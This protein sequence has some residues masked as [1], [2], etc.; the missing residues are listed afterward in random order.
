MADAPVESFDDILARRGTDPVAADV[1]RSIY[2]QESGG[3]RANTSEVNSSGARGPMQVI[4]PTFDGLKAKGLIPNEYDWS[5][6]IHNTEAGI[7]LIEDNYDRY[8]DPAATAA[9]YFS[10]PHAVNPDGSINS[11]RRDPSG[12]TV[13]QY[14]SDVLGRIGNTIV[15]SAKAGQ[16]GQPEQPNQVPV[17]TQLAQWILANKNQQGTEQ[18]EQVKNQYYGALKNEGLT[19][20]LPPDEQPST[21]P[22]EYAGL[23]GS[24]RNA[25]NSPTQALAYG[26]YVASGTPETAKALVEASAPKYKTMD[27]SDIH[28]ISDGLEYGKELIGGM[29]GG[30]AEPFAA[31]AVTT[32][33]TKSPVTGAEAFTGALA[34]QQNISDMTAQAQE[35]LKAQKEG[36]A[37]TPSFGKSVLA[38]AGQVA[39]FEGALTKF[40]L[41]KKLIGDEAETAA[42]QIANAAEHG[43]LKYSNG[44]LE[45][46]GHGV[47]FQ[48][49]TMVGQEVLTRWQAGQPLADD[50]AKHSYISAAISGAAMGI[51]VGAYEGFKDT[52]TDRGMARQKDNI[53]KAI[54]S[55]KEETKAEE[56][57]VIPEEGKK[58][59]IDIN[60]LISDHNVTNE[61]KPPEPPAAV[62]TETK[63]TEVVP[64]VA[65]TKP[66]EESAPTAPTA[67]TVAETKPAKTPPVI[68]PELQDRVYQAML[69]MDRP[70][71]KDVMAS[72]GIDSQTMALTLKA[73]KDSGRLVWDR[74][75]GG[76]HFPNEPVKPAPVF[77]A[78]TES[79]ASVLDAYNNGAKNKKEVAQKTNLDPR[80]VD[81]SIKA[82]LEEGHLEKPTKPGAGYTVKL[83]EVGNE[84]PGDSIPDKGATGTSDAQPVSETS[85]EGEKPNETDS[86]G[87]G[88]DI[89]DTNTSDE[90][91]KDESAA[92]ESQKIIERAQKKRDE[93]A[94]KDL[95]RQKEHAGIIEKLKQ[96]IE[97]GGL[98]LEEGVNLGNYL[99][100]AKLDRSYSLDTVRAAIEDRLNQVA[101]EQAIKKAADEEKAKSL[102]EQKKDIIEAEKKS[103]EPKKPVKVTVKSKRTFSET[104][105]I[106]LGKDGQVVGSRS[107]DSRYTNALK[108][109]LESVGLGNLRVFVSHPEDTPHMSKLKEDENAS[110]RQFGDGKKDFHITVKSGLDEQRTLEEL[111]HEV[112]HI[113]ERVALNNASPEVQ[114]AVR[115]AHEKETGK[116]EN[117]DPA[118]WDSFSEWFARNVSDWT[119]SNKKPLSILEKFFAGVVQSIRRLIAKAKGQLIVP[120]AEVAKFLNEMGPNSGAEWHTTKNVENAE[121]PVF[122][123]TKS[124]PKEDRTEAELLKDMAKGRDRYADK[125]TLEEKV[126]DAF[127]NKDTYFER[128]VANVQDYRRPL[129]VLED[130]LARSNLLFRS[131][132]QMNNIFELL[133]LA[134]GEAEQNRIRA[135]PYIDKINNNIAAIAKRDNVPVQEVLRR[136]QAYTIALHEGERRHIKYLKNVPLENKTFLDVNGHKMTAADYRDNIIKSLYQDINI[137]VPQIKALRAKLEEIVDKYK[138]EDGFSKLNPPGTLKGEVLDPNSRLYDVAGPFSKGELQTLRD[139][140]DRDFANDKGG[141]LE[142]L[143]DKDTGAIKKLQDLTKEME[144]KANYWSKPV[145][146]IANFYGYEH[147][148]PF[149][150]RNESSVSKG[151][152]DL[153][154]GD[155]R[156]SGDMTAFAESAEGRRSNSDNPVLQTITDAAKAA[157]R[158]GNVGVT[159]AMKNLIQQGHLSGSKK[160]I[161]VISFADRINDISRSDINGPNNVFHYMPDGSVE[162][163]KLNDEKMAQAI[164]GIQNDNFFRTLNQWTSLIGK[165]HTR[166]NVAFS[167]FNLTR[168]LMTTAWTIGADFTPAESAHFLAYAA[169]E[170][171]TKGGIPKALKVA[172]LFERG[173]LEGIKALANGNDR[174]YSN[175]K[176]FIEIGGRTSFIK[177][178]SSEAQLED[179]VKQIGAKGFATKAEHVTKYFDI[180]AEGF[181]LAGRAATYG[182]MKSRILGEM[183]DKGRDIDATAIKEA[184]IQAAAYAKN[185]FNFEQVGKY[186]REIG[187]WIMFFRPTVT[188]AVRAIDSLRPAFQSGETMLKYAP[189]SIKKDPEATKRFLADHSMRQ[190]AARTMMMALAGVGYGSV[191][192]AM[193][194]AGVDDDGRNKVATDD[195]AMWTR[196]IRLPLGEA[197]HKIGADYLNIPTGFGLGAFIALGAQIGGCTMGTNS[198][199]KMIGNLIPVA[200]DSYLPLPVAKFNPMDNPVAYIAES[201]A[202]SIAR[203]FIEYGMNIDEFGRQVH[204]AHQ[205]AF[206]DAYT[207]SEHL[208]DFYSYATRFI[209]DATNGELNWSP[210]ALH[211]IVN[212]YA[213]GQSRVVHNLWD[214]GLVLSGK[215]DFDIKRDIPFLDTYIGKESSYDSRVFSEKE[216]DVLKMRANL[217]MFEGTDQYD[218]YVDAHPNAPMIV[219]LYEDTINGQLRNI[220][221]QANKVRSDGELTAQERN[222]QLTDLKS[223]KDY[224]MR[225]FIDMVKDY[226]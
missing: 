150:G 22:T 180:W 57:K 166:L 204:S 50:E 183:K 3:N 81:V 158:A 48:V 47:A 132:K 194:M 53:L 71:Q 83:P 118:Y 135:Q 10:G 30:L 173:D 172:A 174:A 17:S 184:Q 210:D 120:N 61:E 160:P 12:K 87:V 190:A 59:L 91:K 177:G 217:K 40:P 31:S 153:E 211:F 54:D 101:A 216:K 18:F 205:S 162:V 181:D 85:A 60:S 165:G 52:A 8:R 139:M 105:S 134:G 14:V 209:A 224:I 111:T 212:S 97:A 110:V 29:I 198:I 88:S 225:G 179:L 191:A 49:P 58:P 116:K 106:F 98:T 109:L 86:G 178:M 77:E 152:G 113:I 11:N 124:V 193:A 182:F 140:K 95:D 37:Y 123:K 122:S 102:A 27:F 19:Q 164:K 75:K 44:V 6:P 126:K 23:F 119:L 28:S 157:S 144:I 65:E 93:Q 41:F 220:R 155:K 221:S 4:K 114:A 201:A 36:R 100:A 143:F 67:P 175:L 197:G 99:K 130:Y 35:Q 38:T 45:G 137:P 147:Y 171:S 169:N 163:Y 141:H 9:V 70:N 42:S 127:Q 176:E 69:A 117:K 145:S 104:D 199:P 125:P 43:N 5:N 138:T 96:L 46:V 128:L 219:K 79:K 13:G 90:G 170:L 148:M 39:L 218:K 187:S 25:L 20:Y 189:D 84:E 161:H 108:S 15:P 1:A 195:W 33:V 136:L 223:S 21:G 51:G 92:L 192:V 66:T 32:A 55:A 68:T 215:K 131:G 121:T 214:I 222:D 94:Q 24:F 56:N 107:L 2:I 72:L 115:G 64:T 149:K 16:P 103:E 7:A 80:V 154:L 207:S 196:N 74:S 159:E 129:K 151:D 76:W 73:L 112:G 62:A 34:L 168:H 188:T 26:R 156:T 202:P 89:P 226:D 133:S 208:P 200:M 63:P 206:G 146:N 185:M 78:T 82:L 213:D 203:P 142:A 186:G 167:P